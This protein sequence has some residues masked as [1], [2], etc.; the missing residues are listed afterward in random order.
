M[1]RLSACTFLVGLISA[2]LGDMPS[3]LE[4][5]FLAQRA[6]LEAKMA[7]ATAAAI[8]R[9]A[10]LQLPSAYSQPVVDENGTHWGDFVFPRLPA[11]GAEPAP[12]DEHPADAALQF[13]VTKGLPAATRLALEDATCA[14]L[15]ERCGARRRAVV[16]KLPVSLDAL[17]LHEVTLLDGDEAAD[18]AFAFGMQHKLPTPARNQ[19]RAALCG[20]WPGV[21][22]CGRDRALLYHRPKGWAALPEP[23][24]L[25]EGDSV[26]DALHALFV[27]KHGRSLEEYR[28]ATFRVCAP[29]A[30]YPEAAAAAEAWPWL[31]SLCARRRVVEQRLTVGAFEGRDLGELEVA[32]FRG[33]PRPS[34]RVAGDAPVATQLRALGRCHLSCILGLFTHRTY[35]LRRYLAGEFRCSGAGRGGA[36]GRGFPLR[37]QARA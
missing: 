1:G 8:E 11:D 4:G 35:R 24:S 31:R 25:Y 3:D 18:A 10:G 28:R 7:A 32:F 9:E 5:R 23:L 20:S 19:I 34:P 15:P 37:E 17:Q 13:A 29:A 2:A 21:V 16:A 33:P 12:T 22:Q 30:L 36:R 6:K 27:A 26:P 14:A